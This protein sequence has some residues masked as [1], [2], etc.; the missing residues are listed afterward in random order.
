[1]KR[2]T[3]CSRIIG[4]AAGT[5]FAAAVFS[6]NAVADRLEEVQ[7]AGILHCAVVP[8]VPGYAYPDASGKLVGFDI[9]LCRAVAAAVLGDADKVKTTKM[10]LPTSFGALQAGEVDIVTHR[11]TWTFSRDV[12]TGMNYTRVMVWDGQGF[13]VR[14]SL[15]VKS[16]SELSGAT[17]CLASGS[18]TEANAADY[19]RTH[20]MDFKSVT[21]ADMKAAAQ[22][23]NAGRCDV[24]STDKFGLGARRLTFDDPSEHIILPEV[25]SKEPISPMVAH[26]EDHWRDIVFWVFNALIAAEELGITQVNVDQMRSASINPEIQRIL[27]VTGKFAAKLK[28]SESWA[29]NA[30][31]GVGN[32]GEIWDRHLGPNTKIGADRGL[33]NLWTNGGLMISPPFR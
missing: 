6:Q 9:E 32:Y 19:F 4:I 22:A 21:F 12:G 5:L 8:G 17:F 28:L 29:Y 30:I 3:R 27:G 25:I 2:T 26:G 7:K 23:Y 14:K 18:T 10:N 16:L 13:L 20:N 11:F 31:K 33:N 1:M 15:G 24:Y